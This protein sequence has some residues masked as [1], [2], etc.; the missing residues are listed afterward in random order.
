MY[1]TKPNCSYLMVLVLMV[2]V[3]DDDDDDGSCVHA[4]LLVDVCQ[5]RMLSVVPLLFILCSTVSR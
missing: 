3:Y 2:V 1:Y 5:M 4:G